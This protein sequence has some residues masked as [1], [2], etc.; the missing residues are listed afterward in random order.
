MLDSYPLLHSWN[1]FPTARSLI[2]YFEEVICHLTMKLFPEG[3]VIECLLLYPLASDP[4]STARVNLR[5]LY[6][7]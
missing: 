1:F 2:G 7:L 4:P 6:R 5:P 3:P